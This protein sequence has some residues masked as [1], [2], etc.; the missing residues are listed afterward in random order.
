LVKR[1][2]EPSDKGGFL[3]YLTARGKQVAD[4]AMTEISSSSVLSRKR[5]SLSAQERKVMTRLC[6]RILLDFEADPE[7]VGSLE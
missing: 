6:E 1:R 5:I 2:P 7:I 3:V 4:K